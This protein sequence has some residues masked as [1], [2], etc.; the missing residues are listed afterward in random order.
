MRHVLCGALA[1]LALTVSASAQTVSDIAQHPA[2]P[3]PG[4]AE[5]AA[6]PQLTPAQTPWTQR[7]TVADFMAVFPAAALNS[8][9]GGRVELDCLVRQDYRVACAV[10]SEQPAGW[11][12]A[13]AARALSGK[14]R[15]RP[16]LDNGQASQGG[17][18]HWV[19]DF[20]SNRRVSSPLS[21]PVADVP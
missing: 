8:G 4:A 1:F 14:L 13:G 16:V 17:R 5:L 9:V 20:A 2:L 15:V 7:P 3:A 19:V 6:A 10:T 12:F 21:G 11:N 18:L